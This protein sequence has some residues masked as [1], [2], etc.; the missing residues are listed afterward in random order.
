MNS[1]PELIKLEGVTKTYDEAG[2]CFQ[3]LGDVSLSITHNE[4]VSITGPSGSG[5]STL[6]NI[7]GCLDSP[8]SGEYWLEGQT[9]SQLGESQLAAVRNTQIGFIFQSFNLFPKLSILQNVVQPLIYRNANK[10]ER[11]DKAIHFLSRVGLQDKLDNLPSQISGG[12]RQRVAI[13]RAL[14][15]E[16]SI[17]LGDEPTGNLDSITTREI[18]TLFDELHDEGQTIIL[19]THEDDIAEHCARNI[20]VVDGRL[21][22]DT[23]RAKK[24]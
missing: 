19:I 24:F 23:R 12:Q 18:M 7:I 9:V 3:A 1:G 17:L 15:M 2:Q 11:K 4:Y 21:D 16:P 13:A 5:K 8:S 14:A 20:R 6:M 10:K 22:D